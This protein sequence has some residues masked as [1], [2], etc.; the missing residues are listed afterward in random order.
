MS[1]RECV[2][3]VTFVKSLEYRP[4]DSKQ[5][6]VINTKKQSRATVVFPDTF[7]YA[8]FGL[9]WGC[10]IHEKFSDL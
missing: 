2:C 1:V 8:G 4:C 10:K 6:C 9:V 5:L 7:F 3:E